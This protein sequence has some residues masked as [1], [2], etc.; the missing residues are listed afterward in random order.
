MENNF[1]LWAFFL[2]VVLFSFRR[3]VPQ[4]PVIIFFSSLTYTVY[5][6]HNWMWEY[7]GNS[8]RL[9]ALPDAL[10]NLLVP[11]GLLGFCYV[12]YRLIELPGIKLGRRLTTPGIKKEILG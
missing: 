7:I 2:F 9:L 8:V 10:T 6:F 12:V 11:V 4:N 3:K 5:L 1:V